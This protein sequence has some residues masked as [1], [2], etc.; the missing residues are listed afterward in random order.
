MTHY[1]LKK[2][3]ENHHGDT[4]IKTSDRTR[5]ARHRKTE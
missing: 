3:I 4:R 5:L 1:D 2:K